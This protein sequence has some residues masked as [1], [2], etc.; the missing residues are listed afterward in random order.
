MY[1]PKR[2]ENSDWVQSLALMQKYPLATVISQTEQ[3]PFVSHLPLVVEVTED[4]ITLFGHLARANPHSKYLG[5]QP[6]YVIFNGPQ[7]YITPKWY[8]ENDVPT[9]NYAV[10][11]VKGS[12]T[13][14]EDP[15]G[16]QK[17]LKVLSDFA[18][19]DN[20][21]PWEFWIP[22]DLA[23]PGVLEK[24]IVGFSI[25]VESIQSK[26]KL[27]QNRSEADRAGVIRG[28]E[29]RKDDASQAISALMKQ[30]T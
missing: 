21:D 7:A 6:V 8:A 16:I 14:I 2:F 18:E 30:D 17:C 25:Q 19:K 29:S 4:V 1:L 3:G 24:A 15:A 12:C 11:H 20:A 23:A 27:S 13:L 26:F 5:K 9:W 10:V 28:L 22:E